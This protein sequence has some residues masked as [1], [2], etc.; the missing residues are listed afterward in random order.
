MD[1]NDALLRGDRGQVAD[2]GLAQ[3]HHGLMVIHPELGPTL[4]AVAA[5]LTPTRRAKLLERLYAGPVSPSAWTF[6]ARLQDLYGVGH[7]A[8]RG[9]RPHQR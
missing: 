4:D 9:L 5:A 6:I 8:S 1:L 7:D 3:V 2:L